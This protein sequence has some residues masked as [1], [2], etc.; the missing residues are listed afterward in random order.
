MIQTNK[1]VDLLKI[2]SNFIIGTDISSIEPYGSGHI[3]D[4]YYIKNAN[5][6]GSD[7]LLQRINH[8]VFNDVPTLM[9]NI[10][11]VTT[12]LRTKLKGISG[13]DPDKEVLCLAMTHNN[14][15]YFFD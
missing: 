10:Y 6:E 13:A 9:N 15:H 14:R 2:T 4:T 1:Q 5:D 12:H 7:Y 8:Q 3:N 11:L